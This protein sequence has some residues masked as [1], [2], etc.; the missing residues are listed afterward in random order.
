MVSSL[1]RLLL[2]PFGHVLLVWLLGLAVA[3]TALQA[4]SLP[5]LVSLQCRL[6]D[7]PWQDCH[8]QVEELGLHWFLLVGGQ[9]IEFR[10]DGRGKVTMLKPSGGWQP[11]NS[12]WVETTDL[13]W[14]GVCARGDIPLD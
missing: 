14:D 9:R 10:H 12:R 6:A 4:H 5:G 8:M 1:R 3:G 7:G 2:D 11:V 13:C